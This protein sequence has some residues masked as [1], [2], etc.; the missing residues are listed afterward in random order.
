M[1]PIRGFS[2][3]IVELLAMDFKTAGGSA[4]RRLF[5]TRSLEKTRDQLSIYPPH[6]PLTLL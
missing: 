2:T 1:L 4:I 5:G 3:V 6:L